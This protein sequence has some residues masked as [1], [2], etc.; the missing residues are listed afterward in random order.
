MLGPLIR[1][2]E[3]DG[4]TESVRVGSVCA[5]EMADTQMNSTLKAAITL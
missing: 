5:N 2:L 3:R 4:K 1:G